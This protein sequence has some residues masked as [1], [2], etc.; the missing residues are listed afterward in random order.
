LATSGWQLL[1]AAQ[2]LLSVFVGDIHTLAL[3]DHLQRRGAYLTE[4]RVGAGHGGDEGGLQ[5]LQEPRPPYAGV[6]KDPLEVRVQ[7]PEIQQRLVD[8]E[9]T[10]PGHA[11]SPSSDVVPYRPTSET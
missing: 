5:E 10:N 3:R 7:R 11:L 6:A 4:V 1:H 2:D 9:N 8:I